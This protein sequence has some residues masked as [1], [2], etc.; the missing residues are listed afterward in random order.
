MKRNLYSYI[1]NG[2]VL[3]TDIETWS[4]IEISGNEPFIISSENSI[5]G[6]SNISSIENWDRYGISVGLCRS[7]L[8]SEITNEW[9]KIQSDGVTWDGLDLVDKKILSKHYLVDSVKR[10]EVNTELENSN[11][12]YFIIYNF[13][14]H[15]KQD[16]IN[17]K[18]T[19]KSVDYKYNG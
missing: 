1:I 3:G 14:N 10:N 13:L 11:N 5:D 12:D 7:E 2:N 4:N 8:I 15:D 19:P 6:Y 18:N 17:I 16:S 9:V